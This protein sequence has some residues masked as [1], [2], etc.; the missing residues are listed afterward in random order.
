[1]IQIEFDQK[2]AYGDVVFDHEIKLEDY[3][4][5]PIVD[6]CVKNIGPMNWPKSPGETLA[7]KGWE[8][9]A[10]WS[11]WMAAKYRDNPPRT[12]LILEDDVDP[13]R[14]TEFWMKFGI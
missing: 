5:V 3:H 10:D 6:W 12:V 4:R 7:G 13:K 11:R 14:L 1:M 8:V 9:Y 2:K